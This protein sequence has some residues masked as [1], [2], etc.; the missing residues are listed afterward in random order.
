MDEIP[1]YLFTQGCAFTQVKNKPTNPS[2]CFPL[3]SQLLKP[4]RIL[5]SARHIAQQFMKKAFFDMRLRINF[6]MLVIFIGF[7]L[8]LDF[9]WSFSESRENFL[10]VEK[11]NGDVINCQH[12]AVIRYN[13]VDCCFHHLL[14]QV[15]IFFGSEIS[16]GC[17]V[18]V[19]IHQKM[20]FC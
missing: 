17:H 11:V 8:D 19:L 7:V 15:L 3:H 4:Y 2:W 18:V 9:T 20:G 5:S 1:K 6:P 14:F 10:S 13:F 16:P 12:I